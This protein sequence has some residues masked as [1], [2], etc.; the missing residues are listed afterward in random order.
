MS[1]EVIKPLNT[2]TNSLAPTLKYTGKRMCIEFNGGYFKQGKIT[3]NHGTIVNICIVYNLKLTINN[4]NFTLGSSLFGAVKLTKITD[5]DRYKYS[6]CV[7]SLDSNST[8][9]F[10]DGSYAHNVIIFGAA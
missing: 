8:F 7:I 5:I 4:F 6:S 1:D 10:P 9:S 3:F 2:S